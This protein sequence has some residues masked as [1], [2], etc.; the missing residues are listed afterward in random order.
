MLALARGFGL[1]V[2]VEGI[3]TEAQDAWFRAR[4]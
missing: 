2:V 1:S 4:G 3:E